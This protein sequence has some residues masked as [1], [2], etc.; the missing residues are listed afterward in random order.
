M[1][2]EC[3]RSFDIFVVNGHGVYAGT[4]YLQLSGILLVIKSNYTVQGRL[5]VCHVGFGCNRYEGGDLACTRGAFGTVL[6]NTD[7]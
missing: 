3:L 7:T 6:I 2:L 5:L 4:P 1:Q